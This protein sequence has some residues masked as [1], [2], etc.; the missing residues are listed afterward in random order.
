MGASFPNSPTKSGGRSAIIETG[1]V[2]NVN[3]RN[4]T[5]DWTSQYS[6][7]Q[8]PDVQWLTPYLHFNNGEGFTC[9]PEIGALCVI[10]FPTDE[11]S[12]F[13]MGFLSAPEL[14]GADFSK[15]IEEKLV[16][17]GVESEEDVPSQNTTSSG[18]STSA[19][20]NASDASFRAGR[21]I[22]NP[23]D[24]LWQ[25][26]DGNWIALRRGGVLQLGSTQVC[27]RAYIPVLNFIR[28]FCENYELNTAA[29]TLS[30]E[31]KRSESDPS[32]DAPSTLEVIAREYAQDKKASIKI[33]M[34]SLDDATKPP[35][36]DKTFIEVTIAPQAIDPKD[37]KVSG[38]PKYVLRF[39]KAGN[40]FMSQAKNRTAE[41]KGDDKLTVTGK[42]DISV[43]GNRT[44]DVKGSISETTKTT[45]SLTALTS[46]ENITAKKTINA[47][48]LFLGSAAAV[49]PVPLG[50]LLVKW[51]QNHQHPVPCLPN[52]AAA[53]NP[54]LCVPTLPMKAVKATQSWDTQAE[55]TLTSKT[56]FVN[57]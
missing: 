34:G 43:T 3:V 11:D 6:G 47:A 37:G 16:D 27:Q 36:G 13:V 42:Q 26:R 35:S 22:L 41:V 24:M 54:E 56:V 40:T 5:L 48:T 25:G 57:Q 4:M 2:A 44:I 38:T 32:G 28:D 18:G 12:P 55:S 53:S 9:V 1:V 15:F 10:C 20:A 7:K 39:D 23:G 49:Q 17:P 14:E 46:T 31:V 8:I 50:L 21:P 30:W 45:H 19:T 52:P 33:S 51:L 29:G